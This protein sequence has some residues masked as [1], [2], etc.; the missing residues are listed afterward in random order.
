VLAET[1]TKAVILDILDS[2]ITNPQAIQMG[3]KISACL[4]INMGIK[5][6][7]GI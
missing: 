7:T 3:S 6:V 5:L 4:I 1:M 2:C